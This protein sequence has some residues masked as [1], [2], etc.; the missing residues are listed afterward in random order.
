MLDKRS[1]NAGD[2]TVVGRV[3]HATFLTA[4]NDFASTSA[5]A[6]MRMFLGVVAETRFLR[7]LEAVWLLFKL[8]GADLRIDFKGI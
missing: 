3:N 6:K 7:G 4:E 8:K 5:G 2:L 1:Q